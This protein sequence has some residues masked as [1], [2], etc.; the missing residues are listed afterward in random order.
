MATC[1]NAEWGRRVF[2]GWREDVTWALSQITRAETA[3]RVADAVSEGAQ[4]TPDIKQATGLQIK[5]IE[6]VVGK[7]IAEGIW[8]WVREGGEPD[9]SRG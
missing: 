7:R 1:P 4:T 5:E 9:L 8:E 2:R 6:G 3:E